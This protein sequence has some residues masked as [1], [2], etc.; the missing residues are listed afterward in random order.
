MIRVVILQ[1]EGEST[2][3]VVVDVVHEADGG[4]ITV[5]SEALKPYHKATFLVSDERHLVVRQKEKK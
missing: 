1:D 2:N 3:E 4:E 5:S